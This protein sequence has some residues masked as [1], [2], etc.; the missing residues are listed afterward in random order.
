MHVICSLASGRRPQDSWDVTDV[1]EG[2]KI[3]SDYAIRFCQAF[4]TEVCFAFNDH[5]VMKALI[6]IKTI[7]MFFRNR[8]LH[9]CSNRSVMN[10]EN[11]VF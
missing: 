6:V 3:Y 4:P 11:V 9:I 2:E 1:R 8:C 7:F 5:V 10:T